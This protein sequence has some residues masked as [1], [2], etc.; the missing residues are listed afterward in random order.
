LSILFN[1]KRWHLKKT[2]RTPKWRNYICK[3]TYC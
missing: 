3:C 1:L 2:R